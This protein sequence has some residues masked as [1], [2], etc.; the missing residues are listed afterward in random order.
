MVFV[1]GIKVEMVSEVMKG[2][3]SGSIWL[4]K[5]K[6]RL[7]TPIATACYGS[8]GI[9]QCYTTED[10]MPLKS[11]V[12]TPFTESFAVFDPGELWKSPKIHVG[13]IAV[14]VVIEIS[15]IPCSSPFLE[16]LAQKVAYLALSL[17]NR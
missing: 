2:Q 14:M 9:A 16:P 8:R 6:A 12:Q 3:A 4:R 13:M 15:T 17:G 11:I 1:L 7:A 10:K 5:G